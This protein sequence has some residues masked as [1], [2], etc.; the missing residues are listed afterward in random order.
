MA[1]GF[2][3][4]FDENPTHAMKPHEWG[5]RANAMLNHA[6]THSPALPHGRAVVRIAK[7]V[8]RASAAISEP[9]VSVEISHVVRS[10]LR[11]FMRFRAAMQTVARGR[12]NALHYAAFIFGRACR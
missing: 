11:I 8:L 1:Y 2:R 4:E 9:R 10:T 7:Y 5:T 6:P 12:A 3:T